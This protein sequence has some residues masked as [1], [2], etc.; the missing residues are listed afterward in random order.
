[1]ELKLGPTH[2]G[3]WSQ[4]PRILKN[5]NILKSKHHPEALSILKPQHPNGLWVQG[6]G[7]VGF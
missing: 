4:T 1:M 3:I 6:L 2:P 5:L 7:G